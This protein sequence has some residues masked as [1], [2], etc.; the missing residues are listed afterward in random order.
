MAIAT[1]AVLILPALLGIAAGWTDYR[2]RRIPNWVTV[3]GLLLGIGVNS[4]LRG[5]PG[6]TDSLLGAGLGLALLLPFV[7]MRL[8]GAGDWKFMGA[9]GAC[10][11]AQSLLTVLVLA[12]LVNGLMGAIM[13]LRKKRV[14]ET[15]RNIRR[16]LAAVL[17]VKLPGSDLSLDNPDLIK[18][19]FGVA[20][21]IAVFL[22]MTRHAWG[23]A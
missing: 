12:I 19:P 3:P 15:V 2:S 6:A 20:V 21:A 8:F 1:E 7:L 18:V 4:W 16:M 9:L 17:T 22:Y 23:I 14:D 10:L 5:W 13:V 11:G